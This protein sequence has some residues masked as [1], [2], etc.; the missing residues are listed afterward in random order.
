VAKTVA[1]TGARTA[2]LIGTNFV[3]DAAGVADNARPGVHD[4]GIPRR[5]AHLALHCSTGDSY[6]F[7][8]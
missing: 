8:W 7:L 6:S 1:A 2:V 4:A 3:V 5:R